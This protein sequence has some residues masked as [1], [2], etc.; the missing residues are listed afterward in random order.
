MITITLLG[1][2]GILS[3]EIS[4]KLTKNL[5]KAINVDINQ[6]IFIGADS[7][8]SHNGQEQTRF[9]INLKIELPNK[10]NKK[11]I[12]SKILDELLPILKNYA[13]HQRILFDFFD[14]ANENIFLD[15]DYPQYMNDSNM[16]KVQNEQDDEVDDDAYSEDEEDYNEPYMDDII[17]QF[18]EYIK[19]H[20]NASS[21]EVYK[22]LTEIREE[23]TDKHKSKD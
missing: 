23:V 1:C 15:P 19:K 14:E 4:K 2:E 22:A 18:D 8:I 17:S 6:I 7:F 12:K 3:E 11:E 16:V 13:I 9:L 20:P 21:D 5:A 10:Y